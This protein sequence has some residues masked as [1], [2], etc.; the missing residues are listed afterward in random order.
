[1][2]KIGYIHSTLKLSKKKLLIWGQGIERT[3]FWPILIVKT[4]F[5]QF[6]T[7]DFWRSKRSQKCLSMG[8]KHYYALFRSKWSN[9]TQKVKTVFISGQ[10]IVHTHL[11][12]QPLHNNS[13]IVDQRMIDWFLVTVFISSTSTLEGQ[14]QHRQGSTHHHQCDILLSDGVWVLGGFEF[15]KFQW[16]NGVL[17]KVE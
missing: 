7:H 17:R 10:V 6:H 11:D 14:L 8:C 16:V 3:H 12:L 13:N 5:F 2:P 1:M 9:W 15:W 4:H